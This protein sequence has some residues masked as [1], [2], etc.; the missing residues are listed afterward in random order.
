MRPRQILGTV[1]FLVLTVALILFLN[2]DRGD[3]QARDSRPPGSE[4][5]GPAAAAEDPGAVAPTPREAPPPAEPAPPART[6]VPVERFDTHRVALEIEDAD[7]SAFEDFAATIGYDV[8]FTD[9]A[10]AILEDMGVTLHL[11]D[12]GVSTVLALL[13]EPYDCT[14]KVQGNTIWILTPGEEPP[15]PAR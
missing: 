5:A 1:L 14:W 11:E 13:T 8:S 6:R 4:Q 15:R 3:R 12:V 9:G 10:W 7:T 2:R